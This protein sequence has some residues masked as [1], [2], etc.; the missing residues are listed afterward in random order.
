MQIY[1]MV[2]QALL[3]RS[4]ARGVLLSHDLYLQHAREQADDLIDEGECRGLTFYIAG[5]LVL[6]DAELPAGSVEFISWPDAIPA[7]WQYEPRADGRR[8]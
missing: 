6:C 2:E 5:A 1:D 3:L 4:D 7:T 8:W